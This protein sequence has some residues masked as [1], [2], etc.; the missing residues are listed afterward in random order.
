MTIL[1]QPQTDMSINEFPLVKL[2]EK[3]ADSVVYTLPRNEVEK[4]RILTITS[5]LPRPRKGNPGTVKTNL[6][7]RHTVTI[8]RGKDTERDVPVV[9]KLDTSFPVGTNTGD[10]QFAIEQLIAILMQLPQTRDQLFYEGLLPQ[11]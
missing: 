10:R 5:T 6:N 9:L 4:P 7:L 3:S 2:R 8:D 1:I 11:D